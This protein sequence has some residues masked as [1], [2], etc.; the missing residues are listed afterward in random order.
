MQAY[1]DAFVDDETRSSKAN[2]HM[3]LTPQV[4]CL[5]DDHE[6]VKH[7]K[8]GM[9]SFS[10]TMGVYSMGKNRR[11]SVSKFVRRTSPTQDES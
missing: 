9:R 1:R 8:G 4:F 5:K 2:N 7:G 11:T 6:A 10:Q 3:A